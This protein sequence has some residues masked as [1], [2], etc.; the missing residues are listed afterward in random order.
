MAAPTT[1]TI[2]AAAV[3]NSSAIPNR[4]A[5]VNRT[6]APPSTAHPLD[7]TT[8]TATSLP[9]RASGGDGHAVE[10][11]VHHVVGED[12]RQ[13]GLGREEHPVAEGRHGQGLDVVGQHV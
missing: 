1:S 9:G 3:A 12:P 4:R 13:L 7:V 6:R 11:L 2:I 5:A 8:R 10:H